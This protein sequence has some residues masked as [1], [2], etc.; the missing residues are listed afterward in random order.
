MCASFSF[1]FEGGKWDLIVLIPDRNLSFHFECLVYSFVD[2]STIQFLWI[3][4]DR[5]YSKSKFVSMCFY[6]RKC[7]SMI[8]DFLE[9]NKNCGIKMNLYSQINEYWDTF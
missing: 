4:L 6:L 2:S 5:F 8:Y 3:N 7:Y 9:N 1:G